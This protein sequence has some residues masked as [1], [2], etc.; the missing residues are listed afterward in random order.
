MKL[1][2]N[3]GDGTCMPCGE[4]RVGDEFDGLADCIAGV[5]PPEDDSRVGGTALEA[6]DVAGEGR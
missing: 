3:D 1:P 2:F 5:Y 4:Y 6:Y